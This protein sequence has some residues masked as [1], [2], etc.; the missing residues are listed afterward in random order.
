MSCSGEDEWQG[1]QHWSGG[2]VHGNQRQG[3]SEREVGLADW[4]VGLIWVGCA[5]L[6]VGLVE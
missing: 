6:V 2:Q 5:G 4:Q 3:G 1:C